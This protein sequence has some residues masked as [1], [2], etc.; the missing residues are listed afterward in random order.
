MRNLRRSNR[1]EEE[2]ESVFVPMTDMT[3]SFLFILMILLAFFAV[4]FSDKDTVPRSVHEAMRTEFE[5]KIGELNA[6]IQRH[7]GKIKE[8]EEEIKLLNVNIQ[9]YKDDIK[10]L[11]N[12][13]G[14]LNADIQR[15]VGKIKELEEKIKDLESR[16]KQINPLEVYI[17]KAQAQR[18]EILKKIEKALKLEFRDDIL[19]EISPENDA[20]RFKG[21]GLFTSGSRTLI[22]AKRA[23]VDR[24]ARL[25]TDAITCYTVNKREV[26]YAVCNPLG[27]I[28]EAVQI[29]GHTDTDGLDEQN[30]GLSTDRANNA[31]LR[32]LGNQ[33]DL[34]TFK[35]IRDQPV[36]SVAG[37]GEMRPVASNETTAGKAE[38]RRIDLRLIMYTP[39]DREQVESIQKKI[40]DGMRLTTEKAAASDP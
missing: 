24:L 11:K 26:D 22:P 37:Y 7:V 32:M 6:D 33:A 27:I 16:L 39:R 30:I 9:H 18:L 4:R 12:K 25:I 28:I 34:L 10:D 14:E 40:K 2:E 15:H 3:V 38:N 1:E 13:I 35:N 23:V 17:V 19:V 5:I 20:L 31:F 8:L 21:E 36:I 29:E